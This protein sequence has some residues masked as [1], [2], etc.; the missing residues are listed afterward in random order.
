M[1]NLNSFER[2]KLYT[3]C[4]EK[5]I[6][7]TKKKIK[8]HR[9]ICTDHKRRCIPTNLPECSDLCCLRC[10]VDGCDNENFRKVPIKIKTVILGV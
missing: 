5:N 4:E 9:W 2:Y 1:S 8:E 7:F 3:E 10:P 6:I